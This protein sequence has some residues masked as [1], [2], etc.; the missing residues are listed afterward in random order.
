MHVLTN[1]KLLKVTRI[2]ARLNV[3]GPAKHCIWLLGLDDCCYKYGDNNSHNSNNT[4]TYSY[5]SQLLYG[6]VENYEDELSF[7]FANFDLQKLKSKIR[8][9]RGLKR[10]I[11]ISDIIVFSS[12]LYNLFLFKPDIIHTHT[13]KAGLHGRIAAFVYNIVKKICGKKKSKVVH[14]FHGHTLHGYFSPWKEW[15]FRGIEKILGRFCTD[16]I[17]VISS[18]QYNEICLQYKIAPPQRFKIIPLGFDTNLFSEKIL[19]L[20]RGEFRKEL[21]LPSSWKIVALVSRVALIKNHQLFINVCD[22]YLKKFD[23]NIC[24]VIVGGG[25][26]A[27]IESLKRQIK[28]K[29][30]NKHVLFCGN[31]SDL[32]R[33]YADIDCMALTSLNEGTPLSLLEAFAAKIP[34][35]STRVGGIPDIFG[36]TENNNCEDNFKRGVSINNFDI[37]QYVDELNK[38]LSDQIYRGK[39]IDS[40]YKYVLKNHSIESLLNSINILYQE[41]YH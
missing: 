5:N 25:D 32:A 24:F 11:G 33:V 39:I 20:H 16:R 41:L 2:I 37:D 35:I 4:Q 22:Q 36:E 31:R 21:G 13:S 3:G 18:Q 27:L 14:T 28:E 10:T 6:K 30:L 17:V 26:F 9:I 40:A 7:N 34:C 15:I 23:R 1:K 29:Q 19:S 12:I 8:L 38:L